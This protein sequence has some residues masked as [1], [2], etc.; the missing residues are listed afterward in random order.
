MQLEDGS[1]DAHGVSGAVSSVSYS[2]LLVPMI[3]SAGRLASK[4]VVRPFTDLSHLHALLPLSLA[5]VRR[6]LISCSVRDFCFALLL[7]SATGILLYKPL[8]YLL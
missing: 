8:L 2:P 5:D 3:S 7:A 4:P 6:G 1:S